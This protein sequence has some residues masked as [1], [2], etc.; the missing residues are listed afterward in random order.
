MSLEPGYQLQQGRYTIKERLNQG[1]M[2]TI[3]LA[4]DR[5]LT[6]R[7]VAIKENIDTASTTKQQFQHEAV[8]LSR[9][10]HPNLPRV[11]DHFVEASGAQYLVMDYVP[12]DDLSAIL[13]SRS[14][15]LPEKQ[16]LEWLDQVMDALIYMHGWIETTTRKPTPI[17]HRDIKPGN[18][19]LTPN[20][21]VVLVDFGIAKYEEPTEGTMLGAK[22]RTPGYSPLEQYT[23][24]TTVRSDIYALGATYYTLLT[25][26]RPPDSTA[27]ASGTPLRPLRYYNAQISRTTERVIMR[28]MALQASQRY[29]SVEEMRAA[30]AQRDDT[31]R[32][33]HT[34]S[35]STNPYLV[36]EETKPLPPTPARWRLIG[37]VSILATLALLIFLIILIPNSWIAAP[38]SPN[39]PPS[40]TAQDVPVATSGAIAAGQ[41]L[42]ATATL[43]AAPPTSAPSAPLSPVDTATLTATVTLSLT[44]V[45]ALPTATNTPA[46][47]PSATPTEAATT[48]PSA[49]TAATDTAT[50]PPTATETA[51]AS[52]PTPSPTATTAAT[53]TP[54]STNAP[55]ATAAPTASLPASASLAAPPA[56]AAAGETWVN[57]SDGALYHFVPAGVFTMGS[58]LERDESPVHE[59]NLDAFWVMETE[60]TNALYGECVAADACTPPNNKFWQDPGLANHPVTHVTWAQASEYAQWSGGRLPTEAEWE[61]AARGTDQRAFPWPDDEA[62]DHGANVNAATTVTV[63]SYPESASPFG[64]LDMAGNVEE[65]VADWYSPTYYAESPLANPP[66]PAEGL[67]RIVRGGS[68]LSNRGAARTAKRDRALP[69]SGFE[70]VGFRVVIPVAK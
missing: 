35:V 37:G 65:W 8:M 24:R 18:I 5:N 70:S 43:T 20:G 53:A 3:Y 26:Q 25:R 59:V 16:V 14:E 46:D 13:R 11:T 42:S 55:T 15:P 47:P 31:E 40:P 49:T 61:K 45:A 17:I 9:L 48:T 30:L 38:S 52:S 21:R 1:G 62:G 23:G 58:T 57:E 10:T 56:S 67:F 51:P 60:V 63:G 22:G 33:T 4:E 27:I 7:E 39:S 19:K 54:S 2:G 68:Y 41:T 50:S 69:G 29:T 66:G 44:A 36:L 34:P 32:D 6:G 12:G 64:A 28:A